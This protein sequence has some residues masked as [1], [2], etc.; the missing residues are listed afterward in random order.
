M[1]TNMQHKMCI[2]ASQM[3]QYILTK[4]QLT[5]LLWPVRYTTTCN[6]WIHTHTHTHTH[7]VDLNILWP[8]FIFSV[9]FFYFTIL[10]LCIVLCS[11]N[12]FCC[13]PCYWQMIL[14]D[15]C[16]ALCDTLSGMSVWRPSL[17]RPQPID[18]SA[19]PN[20]RLIRW[21]MWTSGTRAPIG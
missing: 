4:T 5:I 6:A 19:Y 14:I 1:E 12:S 2:Y 20:Q 7:L 15:Y 16:T 17:H 8:A 13:V 18:H 10:L 21:S 9:Y 3:C 11:L